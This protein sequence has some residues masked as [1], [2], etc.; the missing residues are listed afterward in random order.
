MASLA[1]RRG[2]AAVLA[3]V[4]AAPPAMAQ[5]RLRLV[6]AEIK[7]GLLY[8]FLRYTE[9][10]GDASAPLIVCLYG[11]DSFEGRLD[12]IAHRTVSRRSIQLRVVQDPIEAPACSLLYLSDNEHAAWPRL[13][14]ALQGRP[15]LTVSDGRG[16]TDAGGM[17]QFTHID[18]RIGLSINAS[19]IAAARLSID[20]QLLRL[21]SEDGGEP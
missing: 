16:F 10:S 18:D 12:P 6:E 4:S 13:R 17:I 9:W 21:A 2:L 5:E 11:S 7:A 14:T 8:S 20:D 1:A 19:A 3:I 15:V